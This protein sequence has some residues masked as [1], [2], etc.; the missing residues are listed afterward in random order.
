MHIYICINKYIYIYIYIYV[1]IYLH[2][3]AHVFR[4]RPLIFTDSD[5]A[6]TVQLGQL[7]ELRGWRNTAELV[8]FAISNSMKPYPFLFHE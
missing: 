4:S 7:I 2:K 6:A 8:L 3:Y 1:H 5:S